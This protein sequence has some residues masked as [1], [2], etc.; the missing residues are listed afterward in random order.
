MCFS[1]NKSDDNKDKFFR[2]G[3]NFLLAFLTIFILFIGLRITRLESRIDG[4]YSKL[5]SL[6]SNINTSIYEINETLI[7]EAS[8]V[9]S[10]D[11][12][13]IAEL[14]GSIKLLSKIQLK[15]VF[16]DDKFYVSFIPDS[17]EAGIVPLVDDGVFLTGNIG[18]DPL[19]GGNINIIVES[20]DSKKVEKIQYLPSYKE[21]LRDSVINKAYSDQTLGFNNMDLTYSINPSIQYNK[22]NFTNLS[23]DKANLIISINDEVVEDHSMKRFSDEFTDE[24]YLDEVKFSKT[25]EDGDEFKAYIL[26]KNAKGYGFKLLLEHVIV[27]GPGDLSFPMDYS[28]DFTIIY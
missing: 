7:K 6:N 25:L 14:D 16:P 4:L 12:L 2:L 27:D 17:G 3:N 21:V 24:F 23:L 20:K 28:N 22:N 5:E 19:S 18:V 11:Y 1:V 10:F 13:Y 8:M 9:D 15:E 26:A